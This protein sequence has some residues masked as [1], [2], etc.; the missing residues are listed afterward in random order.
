VS[1]TNVHAMIHKSTDHAHQ[2]VPMVELCI[3]GGGGEKY[4][5]GLS[6]VDDSLPAVQRLKLLLDECLND[7][8]TSDAGVDC[9]GTAYVTAVAEPG[10]SSAD[11]DT[12]PD[13]L[14]SDRPVI[15]QV[16]VQQLASGCLKRSSRLQQKSKAKK[17]KMSCE[18]STHTAAAE[19]DNEAVIVSSST[20][21]GSRTDHG[22]AADHREDRCLLNTSTGKLRSL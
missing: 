16:D 19:E 10:T 17:Q 12:D 1:M 14:P 22:S 8:E 15:N 4:G 18:D 11:Q 3:H 13:G 6:V 21:D 9:S 5:R 2:A 7:V 20:S